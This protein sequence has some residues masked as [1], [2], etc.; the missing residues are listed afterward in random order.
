MSLLSFSPH[1]TGFHDCLRAQD[2]IR[3]EIDRASRID[4][5]NPAGI[6][7]FSSSEKEGDDGQGLEIELRNVSFAFPSRLNQKSL[8]DVSLTIPKGKVSS[9]PILDISKQIC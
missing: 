4:H 7:T 2:R 6:T 5:R 3:M 9:Q 8:D 1:I